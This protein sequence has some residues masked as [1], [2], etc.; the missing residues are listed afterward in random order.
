VVS[1]LTDVNIYLITIE[2]LHAAETKRGTK[3]IY[4]QSTLLQHLSHRGHKTHAYYLE[5]MLKKPVYVLYS[6]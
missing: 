4:K 1:I 5:T 2:V 3:S 6:Y